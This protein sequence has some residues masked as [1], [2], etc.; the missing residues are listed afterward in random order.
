MD[1]DMHL[2]S[3][4]TKLVPR[5]SF[6]R[7][8]AQI[9][10]LCLGGSSVLG[11]NS[12]A[13]LDEALRFGVDCWEASP[14]CGRVFGEYFQAHPDARER[15]YLTAKARAP[16][17]AILQQD[18]E[19]A[20]ASNETSVI[21][22]FAIHGVEDAAVL[23]NE[24]RRWS[25]RAKKEGKIRAFGFCTHKKMASCLSRAAELDWIDGVQT[26][27]NYR[28]RSDEG[29]QAA[30]RRCHNNGIGIF[31]VKSMGLCVEN[32][33]KL[34]DLPITR[35][36]LTVLLANQGLSFEQAKLRAIWQSPEVT[37][38][39]SLMP[40][41]S[42]LKANVVA[43]LDERPLDPRVFEAL[44]T[45]A[46]G[47]GRYF[48]SR[49]GN[50]DGATREGIPIF[51]VMECLMYA[52]SYGARELANLIFGHIP[53]E[54]RKAL[55]EVDYFRAEADCPQAMPIA[56]LMREATQELGR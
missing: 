17:V 1:D 26:F 20:L 25:E 45:Y 32:E 28:L 31:T 6:G 53:A 52:R 27:Y 50:C 39:C 5:R 10:S 7:S 3:V 9:S 13:L 16:D 35:E 48:C 8:G 36:G 44:T 18:L 54:L 24:V 23:T 42:I 47:T 19:S 4:P 21:D 33:T 38:I 34:H 40:S 22:F 14:F 11:A 49:C 2:G 51:N 29:M 30:L 15:V 55:G 43:A 41:S 56:Q 12:R 37:S 46:A